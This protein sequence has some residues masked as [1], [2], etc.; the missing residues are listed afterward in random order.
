MTHCC[1]PKSRRNNGSFG[2]AAATGCIVY[3]RL[4]KAVRNY[5]A[6]TQSW[7]RRLTSQVRRMNEHFL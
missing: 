4:E 1:D 2:S 3:G 5:S 7:L 6:H